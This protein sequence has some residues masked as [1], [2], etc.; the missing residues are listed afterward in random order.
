[1]PA[2]GLPAR[3]NMVA[4]D[5]SRVVVFI[6]ITLPTHAQGWSTV[7]GGV[8]LMAE[9]DLTADLVSCPLPSAGLQ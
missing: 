2:R 9:V 1:M 6:V 4:A 7:L 5:Y 3:L 8:T